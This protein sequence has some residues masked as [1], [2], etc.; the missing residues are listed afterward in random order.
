MALLLRELASPRLLRSPYQAYSEQTQSELDIGDKVASLKRRFGAGA[1]AN[2]VISKTQN[3]SDLLETALLM[4]EAGLFTPGPEATCFV[5]NRAVVRNHRR[6]SRQRRYD[7][8]LF[9]FAL[10]A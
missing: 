10:C 4:K 6:P 8:R 2:Y 3:V 5:E 9:R 7:E 1:I